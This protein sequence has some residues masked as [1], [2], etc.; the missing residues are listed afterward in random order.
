MTQRDAILR[1][2]QEGRSLTPLD[3]LREM[4]CF[5]LG[6]RIFELRK[7]GFPIEAVM[8]ETEGGATIASYSLRREAEQAE[9][10]S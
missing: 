7:E 2:L 10:W 1:A 6:A 3:A 9:L 5:R 8:V 4:A